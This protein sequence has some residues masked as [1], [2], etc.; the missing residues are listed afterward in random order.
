VLVAGVAVALLLVTGFFLSNNMTFMINPQQWLAYF[1]NR[2]GTLLN[3]GDPQLIPRYLHFLTA[4]IAVGG[5][6]TAVV[7][8]IKEK[9]GAEGAAERVQSGMRWFYYATAAQLFIGPLFLATL[10][11]EVSMLFL[12]GNLLYTGV[13]LA[14]MLLVGLTLVLA[15]NGKVYATAASTV[16]L[17]FAMAFVRDF[18]RTAYLAP[19]HELSAMPTDYQ[20]SPLIVFLAAFVGG[21][22]LVFYML[23]LAF[24]TKEAS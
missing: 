8:R 7:W 23:K 4:A 6:F 11:N 16:V 18:V 2:T 22:A 1:D 10:K 3:F 24:R 14:A 5:L 9:R 20:Y 21:L 12:G 15:S 13:F 17:V 19:Y